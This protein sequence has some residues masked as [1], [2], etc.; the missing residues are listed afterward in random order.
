MNLFIIPSWYPHRCHPLEGTFVLEQAVAVGEL[1]PEWRVACSLWGQGLGRIS[2]AHLRESPR[3]LLDLI[4]SPAS[5]ERLVRENVHEFVWRTPSWN[6]SLLNGNRRAILDANRRNF[7]RAERRFGRMDLLHAHVSY[8]GGWVAMQLS[9][10]T[11][12]PYVVTEHMGPF[13]LK[14]YENADGSLRPYI[15]EPLEHAAARIAVSP[16]LAARIATFG[17]PL[18][19]YVPNVVDERL[20]R[21]ETKAPGAGFTFFTLGG[22]QPVKGIPDL[23]RAIA[24]LLTGLPIST[25]DQVSFRL[26]GYGPELAEY[27][28]LGRDLGIDDRISWLGFLSREQARSEFHRCDAYVMSSHHESFGVV[29]VE[30][31]AAGKPVIATRCGGPESLVTVTNGILVDVGRPDQLAAAMWILLKDERK[32]DALAI[33]EGFL[34]QFSRAAVVDRLDAIYARVKAT[35]GSGP[36]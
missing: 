26:G 10:E 20:Y 8:P 23:L 29:L 6:E 27:R 28:S 32:F 13:P 14:V 31:M 35:R 30:A 3:C 1:H 18:P 2:L 11:G 33:R 5:N 16:A 15:R 21:I 22:M 12:I 9:R 4:L 25:R 17:L 24:V 36:A 34:K 7:R 19:D